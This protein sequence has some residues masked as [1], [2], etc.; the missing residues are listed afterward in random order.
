MRVFGEYVDV[1][2]SGKN[3]QGRPQFRQMMDDILDKGRT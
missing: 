1:G 2:F 3:V